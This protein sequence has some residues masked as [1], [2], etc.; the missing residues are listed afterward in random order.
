MPASIETDCQFRHQRAVDQHAR[1]H[2]NGLSVPSP[3][4]GRPACQLSAPSQLECRRRL[5]LSTGWRATSR[6]LGSPG[7]LDACHVIKT[8]FCRALNP[9]FQTFLNKRVGRAQPPAYP[10]TRT[11]APA[12]SR[13]LCAQRVDPPGVVG[14][15]GCGVC[16]GIAARLWGLQGKPAPCGASMA[17]F[18]PR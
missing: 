13:S 8:N 16:G 5:T 12:N 2:R 14:V 9:D 1:Q 17:R 18:Q 6:Q 10:D 15:V 3:K 7:A 11:A 4:S